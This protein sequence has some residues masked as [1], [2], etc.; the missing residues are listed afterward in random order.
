MCPWFDCFL[1]QK[2]FDKY[3]TILRPTSADDMRLFCK[4]NVKHVFCSIENAW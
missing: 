1:S 3:I 4:E 2:Y